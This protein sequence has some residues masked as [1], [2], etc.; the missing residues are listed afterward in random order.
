[1]IRR[2]VLALAGLSAGAAPAGAQGLASTAALRKLQQQE[3]TGSAAVGPAIGETY[4]LVL[5]GTTDDARAVASAAW[6]SHDATRGYELKL[7][8]PIDEGQDDVELL[9]LDG[10]PSATTATFTYN[11]FS[12]ARNREDR[13][14][15]QL[16]CALGG[17]PPGCDT[18][19]LR[20]PEGTVR[21]FDLTDRY[22]TAPPRERADICYVVVASGRP[23]TPHGLRGVNLASGH[24]HL[25]G[26][27][28]NPKLWGASLAFGRRTFD[29]L[30][31]DSHEDRSSS[32]NNVDASVHW[33]SYAPLRGLVLL[34]AGYRRRWKSAQSNPDEICR[35]IEGTASTRCRAMAIGAPEGEDSVIGSL[36]WRKFRSGGKL[37]LNPIL[38]HDFKNTATELQLPVYFLPGDKGLTGGVRAAWRADWNAEEGRHTFTVA[39]FVGVAALGILP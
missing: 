17:E 26:G 5:Q 25:A 10:L 12:W 16:A 7:A 19:D 18:A 22:A 36:E 21:L 27:H 37:A 30:D 35:P 9:S 6:T 4:Q 24:L 8:T 2:L 20:T 34:R 14:Y 33:G 29:Y 1:M 28:E 15:K 39:V 32:H 11:T 31:A 38:S 23:C 3:M 13:T